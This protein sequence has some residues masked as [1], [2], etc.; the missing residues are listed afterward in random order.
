MKHTKFK[1]FV[2]AAIITLGLS[3]CTTTVEPLD[4]SIN[5]NS[6]S[7]IVG[8]YAMTAF[9]TSVP[10]DLNND[11]TASTNQMTETT[12]FN[13]NTLAIFANN[14]F[15]ATGKGLEINMT[16]TTSTIECYTDPDIT[17]T[18]A[19]VGNVL[20]L[21]YTDG[22]FPYTEAFVFSGNNTLTYTEEQGEVVGMTSAN[23]PVYLTSKIDIVY[24]K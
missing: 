19:I 3:A 20:T 23:E 8:T 10:T 1:T 24:K 11:G 15:T 4:P 16:E 18:W 12:C 22:G 2:F 7:N 9:N 21:T 13:G 6:F 17:G 14:T 5:L